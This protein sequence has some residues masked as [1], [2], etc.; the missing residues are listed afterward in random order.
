MTSCDRI[1]HL[2]H[3]VQ[4]A[5]PPPVLLNQPFKGPTINSDNVGTYVPILGGGE[6]RKRGAYKSDAGAFNKAHQSG[7]RGSKMSPGS[8]PLVKVSGEMFPTLDNQGAGT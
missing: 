6:G 5:S 7:R 3:P 8:C 1:F 2:L 4:P